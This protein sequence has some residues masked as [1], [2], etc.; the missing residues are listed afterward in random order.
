VLSSR[1]R[2]P[3]QSSITHTLLPAGT[4]PPGRSGASQRHTQTALRLIVEVPARIP[5]DGE[6]VTMHPG[7]FII[8]PC[9]PGTTM[10]TRRRAVCGWTARHSS[11]AFLDAGFAGISREQ[12]E[13][14][15]RRRCVARYGNNLLRSNTA[16]RASAL[17]AYPYARSSESLRHWLE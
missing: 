11:V 10:A 16:C 2:R 12:Q 13:W 3:V 6:R 8:T 5:G 9:G 15:G 4:H 1:T 7:D 14:C 17:F